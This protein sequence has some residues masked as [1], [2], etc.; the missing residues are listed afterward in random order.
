MARYCTQC[1]N[2]LES[3][4]CCADFPPRETGF[5]ADLKKRAG[6]GYT[7]G[8]RDD[9]RRLQIVPDCVARIDG[10]IP[11]RQYDIALLR[12]GW[13]HM[14]AK[15]RLQIT[16]RRV[17]FRA[18]GLSFLGRTVLHREFDISQI[19]SVEFCRNWRFRFGSFVLNGLVLLAVNLAAGAAGGML[20]EASKAIGLL[21]ALLLGLGGIALFFAF[22]KRF[23]LKALAASIGAGLFL[24]AGG[25]GLYDLLAYGELGGSDSVFMLIF[26]VPALLIAFI[27]LLL[28]TCRPTL[29]MYINSKS[30]ADVAAILPEKTSGFAEIIPTAYSETAIREIGAMIQDIQAPGSPGIEK[31]RE[32][33]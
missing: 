15:G 10:E 22:P 16:N 30:G 32:R 12:T 8:A 24:G 4:I 25:V 9:E 17:L 21:V 1:G 20:T 27:A 26:A 19:S 14:R 5:F 3:C 11:L 7:Y 18:V 2:L 31:W 29:R 13:K 33:S 23:H 6:V 28:N